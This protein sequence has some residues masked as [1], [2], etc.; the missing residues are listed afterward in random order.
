M[1]EIKIIVCCSEKANKKYKYDKR[2]YCMPDQIIV[3]YYTVKDT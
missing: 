1:F 3:Y 2:K